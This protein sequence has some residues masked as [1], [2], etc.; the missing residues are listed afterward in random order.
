MKGINR[1]LKKDGKLFIASP[2]IF[3]EATFIPQEYTTIDTMEASLRETI[4]NALVLAE[5]QSNITNHTPMG[6]VISLLISDSTIY[7]LHFDNLVTDDI[8]NIADSL[9]NDIPDSVFSIKCAKDEDNHTSYIE[10]LDYQDSVLFWIGR[11]IDLDISAPDSVDS[12]TGIVYEPS[13]FVE[14]VTMDTTQIDWITS[15]EPRYIVPM[16]TFY[17]SN[18]EPR[19][20]L[21]SDSLHINSHIKFMLQVDELFY[22]DS[23]SDN[24][25]I[26]NDRKLDK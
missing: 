12:E 9:T 18:G 13:N 11:L 21:A 16:M 23:N 4:D 20:F 25:P 8:S 26:Q 22:E 5:L 10:F 24:E 6:C 19:T 7:P 3:N 14:T 2:F 1:I 15:E 17:S